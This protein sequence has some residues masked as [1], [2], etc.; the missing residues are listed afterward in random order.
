MGVFYDG[1]KIDREAV[2]IHSATEN[3]MVK[4]G[5]IECRAHDG[6]PRVPFFVNDDEMFS[7]K[8]VYVHDGLEQGKFFKRSSPPIIND[9]DFRFVYG[10]YDEKAGEPTVAVYCDKLNIG[11]IFATASYTNE[12]ILSSFRRDFEFR[13][14]KFEAIESVY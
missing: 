2:F 8:Q 9:E 4:A 1:S 11:K 13:E 12:Q 7:G 5:R 10:E 3:Q 14:A 6:F